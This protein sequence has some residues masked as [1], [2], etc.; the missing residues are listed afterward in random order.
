MKRDQ[1]SI[2]RDIR[3]AAVERDYKTIQDLVAKLGTY[4]NGQ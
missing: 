3:K 1:I 4:Y 2:F